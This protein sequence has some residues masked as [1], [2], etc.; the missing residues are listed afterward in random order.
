MDDPS[1]DWFCFST[2][3]GHTS[4]VWSLA[5]AP[6]GRYLAS[7]SDDRTV[8]VWKR[9]TEHEWE[10][11]LVLEGHERT[12]FSVSWGVGKGDSRG[13]GGENLGWLASTGSDGTINVWE[14]SVSTSV[15]LPVDVFHDQLGITHV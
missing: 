13:D 8:R 9:V 12:V 5:W 4:T 2:L 14:L 11:V 7:A 1:E 6:C 3:K 15:S 10:C